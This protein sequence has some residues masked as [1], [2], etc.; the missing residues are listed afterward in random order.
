MTRRSFL[1]L[2]SGIPGPACSVRFAE[3]Q[4]IVDSGVLGA[5][6]YC[7]TAD[8]NFLVSLG[9]G[10]AVI[11]EVDCRMRGVVVCGS[12]ATLFFNGSVCHLF[13]PDGV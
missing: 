13:H 5:V 3:A 10:T 8:E 12:K 11:R 9:G 1:A 4:R 2:L 7:R 6:A